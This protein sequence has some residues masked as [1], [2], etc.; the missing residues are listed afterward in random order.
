MTGSYDFKKCKAL[1]HVL[2]TPFKDQK[3]T[4]MLYY[5]EVT[6]YFA[7]KASG[8]YEKG[9]P[10]PFFKNF[11]SQSQPSTFETEPKKVEVFPFMAK[12]CLYPIF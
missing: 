7:R 12:S 3:P 9:K 4:H 11:I 2:N 1:C 6:H 5:G 8:D 10:Y